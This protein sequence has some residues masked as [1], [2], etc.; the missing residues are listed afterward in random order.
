MIGEPPLRFTIE[1]VA[2][3]LEAQRESFVRDTVGI[4]FRQNV[5]VRIRRPRWMPDRVYRALM[6]TIVIETSSVRTEVH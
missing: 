1:G 6:R 2:R 5:R 4:V 3:E